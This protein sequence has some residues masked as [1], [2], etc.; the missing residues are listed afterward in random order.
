[1]LLAETDPNQTRALLAMSLQLQTQIGAGLDIARLRHRLSDE[2]YGR[3]SSWSS[4]SPLDWTSLTTTERRI[5]EFVAAGLTNREVADR[6]NVSRHTIDFHLRQIYRR[7]NI[8]SRVA[9]TRLVAQHADPLAGASTPAAPL[10]G[11]HESP[12][13]Q[14]D[15]AFGSG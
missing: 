7:L 3:R 10:T 15:E 14:S 12:P 11:G 2:Q 6:I 13:S 5:S 9:L 1:M 8:N 4:S